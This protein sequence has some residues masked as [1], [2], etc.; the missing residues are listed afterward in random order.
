[1]I[2]KIYMD[3]R[4]SANYPKEDTNKVINVGV[5]GFSSGKFDKTKAGEE[6]MYAL[7]DIRDIYW[8]QFGTRCKFKIVSGLTDMGVPAI[9]YKEA[10][11]VLGS[12]TKTVGIACL[13]V[14]GECTKMTKEFKEKF[15]EKPIIEIEFQETNV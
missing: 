2:D 11:F 8:K 13:I 9:A 12:K 5:V 14:I 7:F 15:P 3:A 1:M 10:K 6:L 4:F